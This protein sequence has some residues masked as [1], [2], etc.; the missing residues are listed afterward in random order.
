ME[1]RVFWE[2]GLQEKEG[3]IGVRKVD[4]G[5]DNLSCFKGY[6][7]EKNKYFFH[8]PSN[9]PTFYKNKH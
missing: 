3:R 1:G 9:I 6:H 8:L 7:H 5:T 2:E 4:E